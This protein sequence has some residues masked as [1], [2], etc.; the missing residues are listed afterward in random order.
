[1]E[2]PKIVIEEEVETS[3][4]EL[5]EE[6]MNDLV[7]ECHDLLSRILERSNPQWLQNE[8]LALVKRLEVSLQWH[9]VH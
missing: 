5:D 4:V 8:G 3:K 6:D 9:K 1:M 7:Y 2:L